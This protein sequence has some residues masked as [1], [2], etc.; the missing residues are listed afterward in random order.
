MSKYIILN[1]IFH[2]VVVKLTNTRIGLNLT[3]FFLRF[4]VVF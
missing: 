4:K 2:I 1:Y 3:I